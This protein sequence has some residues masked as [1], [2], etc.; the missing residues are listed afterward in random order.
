MW[1]VRRRALKEGRWGKPFA[2]EVAS[3]PCSGCRSDSE[4]CWPW[5]HWWPREPRHGWLTRIRWRGKDVRPQRHINYLNNCSDRSSDTG[6]NWVSGLSAR[7]ASFSESERSIPSAV[8]RGSWSR[9]SHHTFGHYP[10][11]LIF[12]IEG[13]VCRSPLVVSPLA[14]LTGHRILQAVDLGSQSGVPGD[15]PLPPQPVFRRISTWMRANIE[16]LGSSRG[17]RLGLHAAKAFKMAPKK[18]S[19][20][21]LSTISLCN[22]RPNG[23]RYSK[24]VW[25]LVQS[26]RKDVGHPVSMRTG[27]WSELSARHEVRYTGNERFLVITMPKTSGVAEWLYGLV[28]G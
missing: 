8:S 10:K 11:R 22:S 4:P 20:Q 18:F 2:W 25:M 7:A 6:R 3:W 5:D 23:I 1:C 27:W 15:L 14:E 21:V 12:K 19:A 26:V 16:S 17:R 24:W 9:N 28:V 13:F